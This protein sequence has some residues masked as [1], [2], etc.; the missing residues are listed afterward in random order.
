MI[1]RIILRI[2]DWFRGVPTLGG[3]SSA[4]AKT[5][6]E[7]LKQFPNCQVCGKKG[8]FLKP[9]EVHHCVPFSQDKSL[10]L[11]FDNFISVCREHHFFVCH[12]NSWKSWNKDVKENSEEWY[13][14]I[15]NRPQ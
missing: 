5:R 8:S 6:A 11:S 10:E 4:W 13:N 7:Y 9:T 3:R 2:K 15:K 1:Q 14:K 12:L